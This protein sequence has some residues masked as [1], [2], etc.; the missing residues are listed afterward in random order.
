MKKVKLVWIVVVAAILGSS[1]HLAT[2]TSLAADASP[3]AFELQGD[4]I[5]V[6]V[7]VSDRGKSTQFYGEI[8]GLKKLFTLSMPDKIS[9]MDAYQA[10]KSQVKLISSSKV[11]PKQQGG[12][13]TA[14]GI[15]LL[16]FL[17]DN[18]D[19][20][21]ARL[22]ANGYTLPMLQ[23]PAGGADFEYGF[24]RDPD[25][26]QIELV[27]FPK[28]VDA[29][30]LEGFQI[31]LT[32]ADAERSREFYGK[33][34]G[35]A[36]LPPQELGN[37]RTKYSFRA[38]AST[39]KFWQGAKELPAQVGPHTEAVGLRY[40]QFPVRDL[41]TT[42]DELRKRGAKIVREPFVFSGKI[43]ILFAADPDGI[44]AEFFGPH[45]EANPKK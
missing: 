24:V 43:W 8:L 3:M 18:R 31:G 33:V 9:T 36:E 35:L 29:K 13:N 1:V 27:F 37:G 16:T 20:V 34:L 11:L 32:V 25:D 26:N 22:K 44:Y 40:I 41:T 15:R 45:E 23:K 7:S 21:L 12:A 39:I 2:P 10:G 5:N 19:D 38:G 42:R 30:R 14:R 4:G 6:V 17:L 28:G